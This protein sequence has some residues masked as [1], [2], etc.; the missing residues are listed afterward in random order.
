MNTRRQV[1]DDDPFDANGVLK[2]GRSAR[3]PMMMRDS[4]LTPLQRAI[5]REGTNWKDDAAQY[6]G[7]K[8]SVVDGS[9]GTRGLNQP[10]FRRAAT[11]T[12]DT[13]NEAYD[14][15]QQNLESAWRT[16]SQDASNPPVGAYPSSEI[17]VRVCVPRKNSAG[18]RDHAIR[19]SE[20]Y[21]DADI[22]LSNAW[23]TR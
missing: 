17:A 22:E 4:A 1:E 11:A 13:R 3:V 8:V 18:P 9:G 16:G 23:R 6:F 7:R 19:M 2:P 14:W 21:R 20:I 5:A 15:Y 12:A 10:G